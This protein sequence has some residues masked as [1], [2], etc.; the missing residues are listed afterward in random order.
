MIQS[1]TKQVV[2][3][4]AGQLSASQNVLFVSLQ[5][6][7]HQVSNLN[8]NHQVQQRRDVS[9]NEFEMAIAKYNAS[10]LLDVEFKAQKKINQFTAKN[11]VVGTLLSS[12]AHP[13]KKE[14]NNMWRQVWLIF[15]RDFL[16]TEGF[17]TFSSLSY[18][19]RIACSGVMVNFLNYHRDA[20][21]ASLE[22]KDPEVIT[23]ALFVEQLLLADANARHTQTRQLRRRAKKIGN[24]TL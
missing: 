17:G 3:E 9:T 21:V 4:F 5:H 19:S 22:I 2:S 12:K 23:T 8:S 20:I 1:Q 13:V 24:A 7:A 10:S 14:T 15:T 16:K 18:D 6:L 11:G